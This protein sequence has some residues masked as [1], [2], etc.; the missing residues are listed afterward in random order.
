MGRGRGIEK[1]E[2]SVGLRKLWLVNAPFV[3]AL[4]LDLSA[5]TDSPPAIGSHLPGTF[6]VASDAFD[7]RVK[8]R[9][10]VGSNEAALRAELARERFV[11][12]QDQD[13]ALTFSARYHASELVCGADWVIRWSGVDG[14]IVSIGA[15]YKEVCR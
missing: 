9:F 10:P 14:K 8:A 11:I 4:V 7:Q 12:A 5:C 13:S 6:A 2:S 1:C 3:L 15:R